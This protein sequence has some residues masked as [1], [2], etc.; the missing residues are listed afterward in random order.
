MNEVTENILERIGNTPMLALRHIAPRNSPGAAEAGERKSHSQ[1]ERPHGV[2]DDRSGRS[3]STAEAGRRRGGIYRRKHGRV[4][5]A[6]VRGEAVSAAHRHFVRVFAREAGPHEDSGSEAADR[7]ERQRAHDR[8]AH[9]E[10]DRGGAL[11]PKRPG[12][13]GRAR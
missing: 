4:V 5:G 9:A 3:G 2:G 11:V 6:G 7:G 12:R 1:H 8:E 13:S 10:H